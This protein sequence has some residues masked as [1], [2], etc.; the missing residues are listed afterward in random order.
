MFEIFVIVA[1]VY[2]VAYKRNFYKTCDALVSVTVEEW[3]EK[4]GRV[5][6][7]LIAGYIGYSNII[8]SH[9]MQCLLI[10]EPDDI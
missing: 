4:N 10:A 3:E 1:E 6:T 9:A 8:L 7:V 2:G 5:I